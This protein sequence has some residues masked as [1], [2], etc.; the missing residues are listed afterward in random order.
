MYMS[1]A[2]PDLTFDADCEETS[3]GQQSG[4][5]DPQ[6]EQHTAGMFRF[7][8][9]DVG[10]L[11]GHTGILLRRGGQGLGWVAQGGGG[12]TVH[13]GVQGEAGRG[14]WGHGLVVTLVVGDGCTR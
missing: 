10:S 2:H 13:G 11:V 12:V 7:P 3:P 1:Q 6:S 4:L 8:L 14:A 5:E 9:G